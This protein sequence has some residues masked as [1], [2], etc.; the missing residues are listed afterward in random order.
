MIIIEWERYS[1]PALPARQWYLALQPSGAQA[2]GKV[3]ALSYLLVTWLNDLARR[4]IIPPDASMIELG[5]QDVTAGR[6]AIDAIATDRGR[7][8]AVASIFNGAGA[9]PK[10][11]ADFYALFGVR[12]YESIDP[13]DGRATY[14]FDLNYPLPWWHIKRYDLLTN[15]GTA[16]HI[17]NIAQA[18]ETMHKLLKSGGIALHA[19]PAYGDIN[20]GFYN[21]HPIFFAKMAEANGYEILDYRYVDN[22]ANRTADREKRGEMAAYG[23]VAIRDRRTLAD[24]FG[25][26]E[27]AYRNFIRNATSRETQLHDDGHSTVFDL[28][29]VAMQKLRNGRFVFPNQYSEHGVH[30]ATDPETMTRA[31][32]ETAMSRWRALY[33]FRLDLR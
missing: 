7:P 27:I 32:A 15:F 16:E 12:K 17:F 23:Y 1:F 19:L 8:D 11:Q 28:Q 3:M 25:M 18:F 33:P 9:N 5:P 13:F 2:R 6:D 31:L 30:Q 29:F 22:I 21:I 4:R 14:K 26:R 24:Y 20:H 10:C